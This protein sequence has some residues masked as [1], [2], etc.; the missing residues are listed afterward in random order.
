[1]LQ[2]VVVQHMTLQFCLLIALRELPDKGQQPLKR[3]AAEPQIGQRLRRGQGEF[4][5]FRADAVH[6]LFTQRLHVFLFLRHVTF[7]D[8]GEPPEVDRTGAHRLPRRLLRQ[9]PHGVQIRMKRRGVRRQRAGFVYHPAGLFQRAGAEGEIAPEFLNQVFAPD[10]LPGIGTGRNVQHF[11]QRSHARLRIAIALH[12]LIEL[13]DQ[14]VDG[15]VVPPRSQHIQRRGK[16][17]VSL[18]GVVGRFQRIGQR[19]GTKLLSLLVV[20]DAEIRR[21]VENVR[22]FAQDCAAEGV[23]G[24]DL[25]QIDA[26]HLPLQVPVFRL[27]GQKL[28]ER[29]DQLAAQLGRSRL[30]KG[31]HQ[32]VVDIAMLRRVSHSAE[33][34]VDQHLGFAGA[35]SRRNQQCAAAVIHDCLLLLC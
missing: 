21:K 15:A 34:A 6:D 14:L 12:A 2:I 7:A 17:R 13:E 26:A 28:T 30:R 29:G 9:C 23:D 11:R 22:V 32:K 27:F 24:R 3:V 4:F 19:T 31:D 20:A 8:G 10:R 5:L 16:L 35:G 18:H 33:D 1:M 25:R